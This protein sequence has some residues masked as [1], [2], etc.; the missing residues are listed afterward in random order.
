[1]FSIN[2]Q[3]IFLA[4][5]LFANK[6]VRIQ[7]SKS[8]EKSWKREKSDGT[9]EYRYQESDPNIIDNP[10][11]DEKKDP[12]KDN[13]SF[14]PVDSENGVKIKWSTKTS[15]GG[16]TGA[17]KVI[18]KKDKSWVIKDY[19]NNGGLLQIKNELLANE[20]YAQAGFNVPGSSITEIENKPALISNFL[21]PISNIPDLEMMKNSVNIQNG[22][23]MD[24]WLANWDVVGLE[25]DNILQA[26][27]MQIYRIDNGG[28]L[29]FRAQG[30]LK[31]DAFSDDV[32]EISTLRDQNLNPSSAEVFKKID[33]KKIAEQVMKLNQKFPDETIANTV[34]RV[35][36]AEP[37]IAEKLTKKLIA[38]KN[39][40]IEYVK[41]LGQEYKEKTKPTRT[42]KYNI[43][44]I[45]QKG[46]LTDDELADIHHY[47]DNGYHDLN[48]YL[49]ENYSSSVSEEEKEENAKTVKNI[50]S[51]LSKLPPYQGIVFR[52]CD[53]DAR[54][55]FLLPTLKPND[56]F[57][58]KGFSSCTY[59]LDE[60]FN[61]EVQ[62]TIR[63][64]TGRNI[65]KLSDQPEEKEILFA[66]DS[67]FRVVSY[68]QNWEGYHIDLE[69]ILPNELPDNKPVNTGKFDLTPE[70]IRRFL[71]SNP[72]LTPKQIERIR[73][74]SPEDLKKVMIAIFAKSK[75]KSKTNSSGA[76]VSDKFT[77]WF[78]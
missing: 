67:R 70:G 61:G 58:M 51:G 55:I 22:F 49:R 65:E 44:P 5:S 71:L 24:C 54:L 57:Y 47:T 29:L 8:K 9:W 17:Y 45:K 74:L 36:N 26:N 18:D 76:E 14:L 12:V 28:S 53:L 34:K 68:S 52:G 66:P 62:F 75:G 41:K 6:W 59:D 20:F 11:V 23:I 21:W 46:G 4:K 32:K 50:V 40:L 31:G 2:R 37:E 72:K 60:K 48:D 64:K 63:S 43:S 69:E 33:N 1:M 77:E 35:F 19:K 78:V 13:A 7:D 39:Y 16:S 25:Y 15:L 27:N 3:L 42:E 56:V 38:R 73:K 10:V 30:G